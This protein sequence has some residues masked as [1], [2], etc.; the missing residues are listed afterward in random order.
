MRRK[1]EGKNINALQ[2]A[3]SRCG[4]LFHPSELNR[5]ELGNY[6]IALLCD[7]CIPKLFVGKE[8]KINGLTVGKV[9]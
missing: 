5:F 8:V 3:C 6:T 1:L 7:D 4:N 2:L 9:L